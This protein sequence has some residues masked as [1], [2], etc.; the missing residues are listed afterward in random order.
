MSR[1]PRSLHIIEEEYREVL[2][3]NLPRGI[4]CCGYATA[5]KAGCL[6]VLCGTTEIVPS[7]WTKSCAMPVK[8]KLRKNRGE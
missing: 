2:I 6:P 3:G 4:S 7:R 5:A 1:T 8:R